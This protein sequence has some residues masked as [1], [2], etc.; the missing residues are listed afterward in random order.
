MEKYADAVK[1]LTNQTDCTYHD[2]IK[3]LFAA[4]ASNSYSVFRT[5]TVEGTEFHSN[6]L[7][8]LLSSSS[9]DQEKKLIQ[10]E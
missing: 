2:M 1:T 9:T 5:K 3:S 7:S 10:Q 8:E 6:F 4:D